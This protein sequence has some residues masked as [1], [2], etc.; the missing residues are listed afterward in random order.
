VKKTV[1]RL[2]KID[3]A[4]KKNINKAKNALR[5]VESRERFNELVSKL[6]TLN[7]KRNVLKKKVAKLN[8]VKFRST[9][10]LFNLSKKGARALNVCHRL[11]ATG[12]VL[13]GCMQDMRLT[14]KP[15]V[16]VKAVQQTIATLNAL[17]KANRFQAKTGNAPSRTCSAVGDPHFTNFNGDYFHIQQPAIYTFAKTSDGL[18]EVQVKQDGARGVGD[19]SYVRDVMIRYDGKIY[20]NNFNKNGF[21][22]RG[23][24]TAVS[25]TVPGSYQGEMTGICGDANPRSSPSNFK[26]PS[27]AIADVNYG[28]PNWQIGGYGGPFTKLSR[29]HLSWRPSLS[30]C[31][32]SQSDCRKNL[33]AQLNKSRNRYVNTPFGRVDTLA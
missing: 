25:V 14:K 33:Q 17:K 29:W 28:K 8:V 11:G 32:F 10:K 6:K 24:N 31:M 7:K 2:K 1:A 18:F 21:I 15:S 4:I 22:V 9:Q 12:S 3:V 27:G 30:Q 26:L 5:V 23:G 19:P 13:N 20:H 16:V